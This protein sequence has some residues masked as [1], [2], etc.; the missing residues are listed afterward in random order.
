MTTHAREVTFAEFATVAR[1][2]GWTASSLSQL[3]R[4][5]FG[6]QPNQVGEFFERMFQGRYANTVI[7]YRSVLVFFERELSFHQAETG[8]DRRCA[9]GCGQRVWDRKKWAS[10]ACRQ[11][12]HRK[13]VGDLKNGPKKALSLLTPAVTKCGGGAG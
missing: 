9:C 6:D 3:F 7:P 4:G 10:N 11:K 1:R 12:W 8:R 5:R 13:Q 2:R